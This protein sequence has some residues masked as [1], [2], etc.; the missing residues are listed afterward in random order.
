MVASTVADPDRGY[1]ACLT[2]YST[3]TPACAALAAFPTVK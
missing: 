2:R 3:A 1:Q